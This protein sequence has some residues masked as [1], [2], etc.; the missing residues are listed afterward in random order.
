METINQQLNIYPTNRNSNIRSKMARGAN[1]YQVQLGT[2][3]PALDYYNDS[4]A[5]ENYRNAD[6]WSLS[7][8]NEF[9]EFSGGY[10]LCMTALCRKCK[11]ECKVTQGLHYRKDGGKEC[12][13][14][15]KIAEQEAQMGRIQGL[16]GGGVNSDAVKSGE[17]IPQDEQAPVG[18]SMGAKVGIAVALVAVV[19]VAIYMVRKKK[20]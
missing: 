5:I 9:E 16:Q 13:K 10:P 8:G 4:R 2:E 3:D 7:K 15:C 17:I 18:M 12:F 19:G 6:G 1:Q 20:S 14:T 11:N